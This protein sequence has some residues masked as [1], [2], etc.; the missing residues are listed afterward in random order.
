VISAIAAYHLAKRYGVVPGQSGVVA[1]QGNYT[2]RLGLRLKDAGYGIK[3]VIDTR[4][5]PQS[6]FI[7]FAKASGLTIGSGQM[8]LA[9]AAPGRQGLRINIANVGT[10]GSALSLDADALVVA[11]G[12]QPELSLWMLAG[13]RVRWIDGRLQAAGQLDH[14][15]LAGSAVG[16]KTMRACA[17]SG[18]AAIARLLGQPAMPVEDIE[19]GASFETPDDA[20]PIAPPAMGPAFLDAGASLVA[21]P[22][23]GGLHTGQALG[24]GDVTASVDLGLIAPSDAGAVAEERGAPGAPLLASAWSPPAEA[25]EDSPTY[26]A[27]RFG[28]EPKRVHLIVDQKQSFEIGALVYANTAERFPRNAIGVIVAAGTP[29]G[30]ALMSSE[31]L[32]RSD[33]FIVETLAGPFPARIKS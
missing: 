31:G 24:L 20:T 8:P 4:I 29:G 22:A 33:R 30:T 16:L 13:G 3:R 10:T 6:R 5:N 28:S 17:Q 1:T 7:D 2:Y 15:A 18:K 23:T 26:L 21:R 19:I 25:A 12:F 27:D 14:F 9:V 32:A 11:G